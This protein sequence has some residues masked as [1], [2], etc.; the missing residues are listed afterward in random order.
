MNIL[1]QLILINSLG[2]DYLFYCRLSN[3]Y[4]QEIDG[5]PFQKHR[6]LSI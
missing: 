5:R 2:L 6:R 3:H 1:C 4:V